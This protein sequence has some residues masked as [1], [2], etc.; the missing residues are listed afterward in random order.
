[1]KQDILVLS[2]RTDDSAPAYDTLAEH[3]IPATIVTNTRSALTALYAHTPAFLWLDL[4]TDSARMFLEE[5]MSR[6]LDPL[7]HI[8]LT[9]SFSGS[10]DRADMLDLGADTCVELPVDLKEIVS[11]LN[12]ALR[13][14]GRLKFVHPG[15]LLPRIEY[16]ELLIDPLRR[17]V[18]MRGKSIDLTPKSLTFCICSPTVLASFLPKSK[19]TLV[20]GKQKIIWGYPPYPI[21]SPPCVKSWNFIPETAN[22]SRLYLE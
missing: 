19:Y 16:K 8:I 10:T 1:M 15:S 22:T 21:I 4:D 6:F 9:S 13:R 18:R 3:N 14:E 12:A 2:L 17:Q 20:Y 11:I 5:I 7:P